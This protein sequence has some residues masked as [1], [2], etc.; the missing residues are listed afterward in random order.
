VGNV[1]DFFVTQTLELA[2]QTVVVQIFPRQIQLIL[3]EE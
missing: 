2:V 3:R 1:G